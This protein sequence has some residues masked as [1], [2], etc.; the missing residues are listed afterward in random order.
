MYIKLTEFL[1]GVRNKEV[2]EEP[3]TL[4]NGERGREF[5]KQGGRWLCLEWWSHRIL[6][7]EW[8]EMVRN[9]LFQGVFPPEMN[10]CTHMQL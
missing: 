1:Y 6:T 10:V 5:C 3:G 2:Y 7:L 4:I 9:G 8:R